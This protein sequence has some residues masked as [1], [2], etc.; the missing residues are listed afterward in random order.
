MPARI[1]EPPAF[2]CRSQV[3]PATA[4]PPFQ[5]SLAA[6]LVVDRPRAGSALAAHTPT[7]RQD[8]WPGAPP[9]GHRH[10]RRHS[11]LVRHEPQPLRRAQLD[12]KPKPVTW[13]PATARVDE[14]DIS[15]SQREVSD[16]VVLADVRER[17]Q[18][19]QLIIRELARRHGTIPM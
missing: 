14:R 4:E 11:H 17:P 3:R 19:V 8:Q 1:K 6:V 18:L 15:A 7:A 12:G 5:A 13:A 10:R 16:Q 2:A 9:A